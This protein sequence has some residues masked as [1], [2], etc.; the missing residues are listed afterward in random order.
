[1]IHQLPRTP[2]TMWLRV[3]GRGKVQSQ[4]LNELEALPK[5]NPWRE[6]A[7]LLLADLLSNIEVNPDKDSEDK[8]LIMRLSPAFAQRL[9]K[10]IRSGR[11]DD[12]QRGMKLGLLLGT[13]R[14]YLEMIESLLVFRFAEL[15]SKLAIIAE[16][17]MELED[18][19]FNR[20]I[21]QLPNLSR[22]ELLARFEDEL[23]AFFEA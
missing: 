12:I 13:R 7:L 4:A 6:N 10:A 20:L 16:E 5:D 15:D 1:M 23:L 2:E 17:I 21:L 19:D 18:E 22:D 9:E 14:G 8:E 3:L 11:Q